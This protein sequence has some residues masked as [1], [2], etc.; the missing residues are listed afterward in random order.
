MTGD[1][2]SAD[3]PRYRQVADDL[4]RAIAAGDFA[5]GSQ[6]PTESELCADHA[7]SRHTAREAL[8]LLA[9]AGLIQ[10]RQGSGS[11][12]IAAAPATGYVH[13]MRSLDELFRYAADTHLALT[14]VE[15]AA[16]G[17]DWAEDLGAA[18]NSP[19]VMA[20]GLRMVAGAPAPMAWVQIFVNADFAA[21]AA[22]LPGLEGAVYRHLE[23]SFGVEVA[24]VEQL[25]RVAPMPPPAAAALR[26]R[27]RAMAAR[28]TRR[29][30]DG[31]GRALIV[32]VSFHPA[33]RFSYSMRLRRDPSR[34]G[35]G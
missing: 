34:A 19:W 31:S 17:A 11:L 9:E 30:L 24:E 35:W 14:E 7:I 13:A 1:H 10:R 33:E 2:A 5:V 3:R 15:I 18:C 6:L 20:R 26:V 23:R 22:D 8:R 28:V 16:P 27:P 21:I 29:Y 12:V 32:S 4:R 25:I